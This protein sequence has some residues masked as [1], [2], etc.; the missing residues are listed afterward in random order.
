M[1]EPKS[2]GELFWKEV[3]A[4][5]PHIPEK[6]FGESNNK[7]LAKN[8]EVC[9]EWNDFLK[10]NKMYYWRIIKHYTNCSDELMKDLAKNL[11][12]AIEIASNLDAIFKRFPKGTRQSNNYLKKWYDT[13]L[14]AAADTGDLKSYHLI[15][16]NVED[17]NPPIHYKYN[18]KGGMCGK[19]TPL[20]LA[21][22]NGDFNVFKLIFDTVNDKNPMDVV[23][24]TPFHFAAENGHVSICQ[25][26]IARLEDKNPP[27]GPGNGIGFDSGHTPLHIAAANGHLDVCKLITEAVEKANQK[28]NS[29]YPSRR[30]TPLDLAIQYKHIHVQKYLHIFQQAPPPR[31]TSAPVQR[32]LGAKRRKST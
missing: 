17:K 1:E 16:E 32:D 3:F 28:V 2:L 22:K 9:K 8:R 18:M 13:P 11:K 5:A 7:N 19:T 23:K 20:H 30:L 6:I 27:G 10:N 12:D 21:A 14:H 15:M 31:W 25:L 4:T 29:V 26:I 24:N